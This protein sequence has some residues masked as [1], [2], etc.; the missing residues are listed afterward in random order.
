VI[1]EELAF[2]G[3]CD[4]SGQVRG[5]GIPASDLAE[6]SHRAVGWTPTNVMITAFGTI[7][8]T[9]FGA[10]GDVM[11]SPD[12]MAE[13]RVDFEDE[14]PIERLILCDIRNADGSPW[15]CCPREFLRRALARLEAAAGL[16]VLAGFEQEFAYTGVEGDGGNRYWLDAFRRQG[17]FG[18]TYV[19]ALKQAGLEP[20]CFLAEFGMQQY[21]VTCAPT[22]G[23]SAADQAVM[24]RELARATAHRFGHRAV[25]SPIIDVDGVGNGVHI[26]LSLRDR[27]GRSV[28]Y[29]PTRPYNLSQTGAAFAAGILHHLPALCAVTAP[30][31]ISYIRMTPNRWAPTV[32]NIAIQDRA[33]SLRI[34]PIFETPGGDP[35]RQFNLEYR[36]ADAAASPY[37][38]LG[39]VVNAGCEGLESG[40]TLPLPEDAERLAKPLP[41]S[42]AQALDLLEAT[43][44]ARAWF[45]ETLLDAYLKH[46]RGEIAL[47]EKLTPAEQC[48]RYARLY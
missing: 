47:I 29:D 4:I 35:Q 17:A 5:K 22:I 11:L 34:C 16:S 48:A 12:R 10:L 42:L 40:M 36:P 20:E 38:A 13:M 31:V 7:G 25:F 24:I 32:A 43:P 3:T 9:P 41:R 2:L 39:A 26:H 46:K 27:S 19:A 14:G 37:L 23:I 1:R 6:R 18:E 30:S 28:A 8:E 45:G 21:E 33:A 44:Q 15:S